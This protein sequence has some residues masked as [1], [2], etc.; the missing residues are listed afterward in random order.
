MVDSKAFNKDSIS[1]ILIVAVSV[2]LV[3]SVLVAGT[4]VALKPAQLANKQLDIRKNILRAAGLM[5]EDS[6]PGE[7]VDELFGQ[8][9]V[10]IID[11]KSGE[12]NDEI[13]I[14][15]FDQLKSSKDPGLSN[16]LSGDDDLATLRRLERYSLVYLVEGEHGLE[17]LV[18]PIRGYG[19]WG[20]LYGYV[21]IEGDLNT[22]AGLAF[23]Q[24]KETPGL[25]GEVDNPDWKALWAGVKI[26]TPD[27]SP[28]ISLVK[29]RSAAEST[30][31]AYEVD[32]LSGATLTSRGVQ[33]L[34]RFWMGDMGFGPFLKNLSKEA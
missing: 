7:Q 32:A 5:G 6:L 31:A 22:I 1:N 29:T 21:A 11:L 24:H 20:T 4:A 28:A 23:Y 16:A 18:L 15:S 30:A 8:F 17:K 13:D 3:C 9:S 19:L 26:F 25:G 12:Y 33:N 10:K 2:C 34:M 27:G 14:D